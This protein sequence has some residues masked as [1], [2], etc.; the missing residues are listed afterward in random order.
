MNPRI[1]RIFQLKNLKKKP[2]ES[3]LSIPLL[4]TCCLLE[5]ARNRSSNKNYIELIV[6]NP[7][8]TNKKPQIWGP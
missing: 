8:V 1:Q 6:F 4:G 7:L 5:D 3:L 2:R